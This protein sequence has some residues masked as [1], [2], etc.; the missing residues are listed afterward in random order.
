MHMSIRA[1]EKTLI[2]EKEYNFK[3]LLSEY[4]YFRS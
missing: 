2:K 3:D 1:M 4:K